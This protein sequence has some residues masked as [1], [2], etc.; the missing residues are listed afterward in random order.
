MLL[1][2]VRMATHRDLDIL[3]LFLTDEGD[4]YLVV[5]EANPDSLSRIY[6][7]VPDPYVFTW[8]RGEALLSEGADAYDAAMNLD[9]DAFTWR[10]G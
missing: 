9:L 6:G 2:L 8:Y 4:W 1:R 7:A 3:D 10:R 5:E